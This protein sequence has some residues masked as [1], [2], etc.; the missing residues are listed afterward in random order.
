MRVEP[1]RLSTWM[2]CR[3][4]RDRRDKDNDVHMGAVAIDRQTSDSPLLWH[5]QEEC[6][7]CMQSGDW[8]GVGALTGAIMALSKGKGKGKGLAGKG[9]GVQRPDWRPRLDSTCQKGGGKKGDAFDGYCH[10]CNGYG[11]RKSQCR[12]LDQEMAA[13]GKGKGRG[14]GKGKDKGKGLYCVFVA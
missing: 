11:H 12:L 14:K 8:D 1:H 6:S 13:K 2:R 4:L 5:L 9:P 10:Y 3:R 7:K